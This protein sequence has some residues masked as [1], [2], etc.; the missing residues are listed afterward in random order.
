MAEKFQTIVFLIR[1]G[2]TDHFYSVD[3]TIDD[4]RRLTEQGREQMK[5]V[6][7]Y[8]KSFAPAAIYSSPRHRTIECSEIIKQEAEIPGDI[9]SNQALVEVYTDSDYNSLA[10]RLPEF[11]KSVTAK[12]IG[13]QIVCVSHQDVIQGA[14]NCYHLDEEEKDF[15]CRMGEG[16]RLVFAQDRLVECIKIKPAHGV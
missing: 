8:L 6:G 1:H 9:I 10:Q 15:P 12:H 13:E 2:Q 7:E 14:L 4:Q 3:Q 11:F 5:R 16:Y